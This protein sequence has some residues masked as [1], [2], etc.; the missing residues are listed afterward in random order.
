MI[1]RGHDFDRRDSF[2]VESLGVS[3][4]YLREADGRVSVTKGKNDRVKMLRN[5]DDVLTFVAN[6]RF[7]E[8]PLGE[9]QI[10]IDG[11]RNEEMHHSLCLG[12]ESAHSH[13][14]NK[15]VSVKG[16]SRPQS[17]AGFTD[18]SPGRPMRVTKAVKV[19]S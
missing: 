16:M 4:A 19:N 5:R 15:F 17:R 10:Q 7:L 14:S 6:Q 11:F 18:R 1:A 12:Y 8:L 13:R 3:S 9:T 2:G